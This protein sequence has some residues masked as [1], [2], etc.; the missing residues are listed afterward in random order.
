M[1]SRK[2]SGPKPVVASAPEAAVSQPAGLGRYIPSAA[3]VRE[4]IESIALALML[5]FL[6]S[7]FEAEAFVIPTG[8]MAPTLMGRHKDLFCPKCGCPYQVGA[9][10]EVTQDGA[11]LG[12]AHS[13]ESGTCPM[14]RY[15]ANLAAR[16][17]KRERY[18]SYNGDRIFV[19]K[20]PYE[21][22]EPKRWDVFVFKYPGDAPTNFIK[23]L[24]GLPNETIRIQNGDI[25]VR[26][27]LGGDGRFT[28]AR[29][30]PRK[31]LAMLQPVF[32]NQYMPRIAESGW[33]DRWVSELKPLE[34]GWTT[35]DRVTFH[36][37]GAAKGENWLRYR[38]LVPNYEQW[39]QAESPHRI[40][41]AVRPQL[42]TDFT[43]YNTGRNQA[44]ARDHQDRMRRFL[45]E[46][47]A[48]DSAP[49]PL[50]DDLGY[51]WVGDL[52]L[53]CLAEPEGESGEWILELRKGGR[54]FQCRFDLAVG[55][56]VLAISGRDMESWRPAAETVLRG[57]GRHRILFSNCDNELRLWIDG[58]EVAFDRSTAYDD[59]GN[60]MPDQ[61]D[62]SPVGIAVAGTAAT[63]SD[64]RVLRDI[65]Y[66]ADCGNGVP[67]EHHDVRYNPSDARPENPLFPPS[68]ERYVDFPLKSDQFFGLGDNSAK[69]KDGRLWGEEYWVKR[70]FL[71]GKALLIYW[72]HSWDKIPYTDL[73][74]Y[75]FP[76]VGRMGLVR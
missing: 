47:A 35:E 32:D 50:N 19:A 22:E 51:H 49:A 64:L 69:S 56:A 38:H 41:P 68:A 26:N 52:A 72:P 23:R 48:S 20:Y 27:D 44:D 34:G 74:C 25:W 65:Y 29:K 71:I 24:I 16:N 6:F 37:D 55:R 59:L 9:S 70:D 5:A 46:V 28:I 75:F 4:S 21:F 30:P 1:S 53:E 67:R 42:I 33:P 63:V 58:R 15:T 18:P 60:T 14:C 8:S 45:G 66:I 61:S 3:A 57:K 13:V 11:L 40:I 2:F 54:R 43:A 36:A 39:R 73:P 62:L 31:L 10:E 7:T 12:A 17:G 76:N